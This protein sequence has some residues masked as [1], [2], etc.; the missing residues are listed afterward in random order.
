MTYM[1]EPNIILLEHRADYKGI[2]GLNLNVYLGAKILVASTVREVVGYLE[3]FASS[4]IFID[5]GGY[6]IDVG[7]QIHK[8]LSKNNLKNQ[9]FLVGKTKAP[10]DEITIFDAQMELKHI[11]QTVAKILQVT[12]GTMAKKNVPPKFPLPIEFI[13]PGWECCHCIYNKEDEQ[14]TKILN[15]GDI[16]TGDLLDELIVKGV[17]HLYI[18]A[19]YRLKFVNSFTF[20]I[21]SK[22]ND[23]SL[24]T[25]DRVSA[26]AQAYQM[27]ME[28]ARRLG[29]KESTLELANNCVNSVET[30]IEKT[31][32]L[33]SLM[34]NLTN[35]RNSYLY[36]HSLLISYIGAHILKKMSWASRE[37]QKK[38]AF[39]A[40][41]HDVVLTR[42]EL[43]QFQSDELVNASFL[44]PNEKKLV[45]NH[46]MMAAKLIAQVK[47]IPIGTDIIIRQHHGS[48]SGKSL[49]KR[50]KGIAPMSLVFMFSEEWAELA[51]VARDCED[52]S[53]SE[54]MLKR[55]LKKYNIPLFKKVIPELS[56]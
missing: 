24:S 28:Q 8:H 48:K 46:A 29:V 22:L 35:K 17:R 30:I 19:N 25:K 11:L 7:E 20:Q 18:D 3:S 6:T 52:K 31:P 51:I 10:A 56:I 21:S 37:Q 43:A 32:D 26:T 50:E 4:L 2:Y 38:F 16:I 49:S 39:A 14:Y 15:Q 27:V 13:L 5:T 33:K 23:T 34:K 1:Q 12:S 47:S 9:C 44:P 53:R 54:M 55:L 42:D 40:F 36:N 41:F 45:L